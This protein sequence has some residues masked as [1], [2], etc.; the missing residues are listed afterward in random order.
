MI[1]ECCYNILN[2][3]GTLC[4]DGNPCTDPDE[5]NESGTCVGSEANAADVCQGPGN[6]N[7][8]PN[9]VQYTCDPSTGC[10]RIVLSGEGTKLGH[11]AL[12]CSCVS[13]Y[14][15]SRYSSVVHHMVV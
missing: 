1:Q 11:R 5:C 7:E 4:D 14:H 6:S 9:C 8:D 15:A 12:C 2:A 10:S 13:T 3:V